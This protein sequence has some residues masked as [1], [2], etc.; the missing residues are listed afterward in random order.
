MNLLQVITMP[1]CLIVSTELLYGSF[2]TV[3]NGFK[4]SNGLVL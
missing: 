3:Q 4:I 1:N 2:L